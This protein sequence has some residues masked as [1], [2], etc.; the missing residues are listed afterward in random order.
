[1][2]TSLS[3]LSAKASVAS[4]IILAICVVSLGSSAQS[5]A[6]Q[7]RGRTLAVGMCGGCHAVGPTDQSPHIAAPPFRALG[8]TIDFDKFGRRLQEGI[9][10][11]HQ[12]MPMFR[13]TRD[14]ARALVAYMRSIQVP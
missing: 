11:G 3:P 9:L 12:D 6:L 8:R 1:M 14:D 13:F 10:T 7:Q 4:L 2:R 5:A